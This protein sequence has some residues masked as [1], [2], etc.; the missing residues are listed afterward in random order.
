[1]Y[2]L[3][4]ASDK[5]LILTKKYYQVLSSCKKRL[6]FMCNQYILLIL[7]PKKVQNLDFPSNS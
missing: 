7:R 6:K 4:G 2:F 1:M 3:F 5:G